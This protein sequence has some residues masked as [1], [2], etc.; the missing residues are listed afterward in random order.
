MNSSVVFYPDVTFSVIRLLTWSCPAAVVEFVA[1]AVVNAVYAV[2]W[3]RTQAHIRV[4]VL[5]RAPSVTYTDTFGSIVFVAL[6]IRIVTSGV[7][8]APDV[9]FG[10]LC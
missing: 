4:K 7:H 2:Y 9:V 10:R 5:E 3:A 8:I 6:A 1:F